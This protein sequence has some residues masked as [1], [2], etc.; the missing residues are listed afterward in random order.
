MPHEG[1]RAGYGHAR[2]SAGAT[3]K[4]FAAAV[5]LSAALLTGCSLPDVPITLQ[6]SPSSSVEPTPTSSPRERRTDPATSAPAPTKPTRTTSTAAASKRYVGVVIKVS[7]GDTIRVRLT[8]GRVFTIRIIGIDTPETVDPNTPDECGG[9]GASAFAKAMLSDKQVTLTA[10]PTQDEFDRYGRMLA[11]VE[12]DGVDYGLSVLRAGHA[13]EYTYD[14]R[15]GK[16]AQ[17]RAAE[18]EAQRDGRGLWA[19]CSG[20]DDPL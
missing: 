11:Y 12:V 1:H 3:V 20:I 18:Q 14:E 17:Y 16:Q 15:Y 7:D 5:A 2:C 19:H 10:D 9:E 6:P 13:G 4:A 8:D